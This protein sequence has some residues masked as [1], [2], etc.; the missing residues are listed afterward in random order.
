L[1]FKAVVSVPSERYVNAQFAL[2]NEFLAVANNDNE[3]AIYE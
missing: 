2:T 3:S 1:R